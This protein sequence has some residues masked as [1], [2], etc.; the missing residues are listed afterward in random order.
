LDGP[1]GN[2]ALGFPED[3]LD[4]ELEL[5]PEEVDPLL[6]E[7]LPPDELELLDDE[8]VPPPDEVEV[9]P[10]LQART[11]TVQRGRATTNARR[12]LEMSMGRP[13]IT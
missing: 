4:E 2:V 9:P 7:E 10:A 5:P 12:T 3:P 13:R 1:Q 8:P 11:V 6:E